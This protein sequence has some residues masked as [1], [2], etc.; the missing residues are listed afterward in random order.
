MN[1]FLHTLILTTGVLS[2]FLLN[3]QLT[4]A[5]A[6]FD[7][8]GSGA[9]PGGSILMGY[10]SRTCDSTIEG[11]IRFNSGSVCT[12]FCNG[13]SWECPVHGVSDTI[14]SNTD[15]LLGYWKFDESSGTTAADS[16]GNGNNGTLVNGPIWQPAD[17]VTGGSLLL[18]GTNDYVDLTAGLGTVNYTEVTVTGWFRSTS[19]TMSDD[20]YL[21]VAGDSLDGVIMSVTDDYLDGM[22][23]MVIA[24]TV[25]TYVTLGGP[26]VLDQTWHFIAIVRQGD[27]NYLYV[28]GEISGTQHNLGLDATINPIPDEVYIG[29]EPGNTEQT[30]GSVDNFRLYDRALGPAEIAGLYNA[31]AA[32]P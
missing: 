13:T 32:C 19:T 3:I 1:T 17:G 29:D 9:N 2:V 23:R 8:R 30:D 28:N 25:H 14:C 15:G 27:S 4:F 6:S 20:M 26:N 21:F 31:G 18:D 24:D 10:D 16:S 11:A 5:Q 12:E 7:G 22:P